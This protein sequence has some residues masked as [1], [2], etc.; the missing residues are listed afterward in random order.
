MSFN[1]IIIMEQQHSSASTSHAYK[2][3][4]LPLSQPQSSTFRYCSLT[5]VTTQFNYLISTPFHR[6][7]N[8]PTVLF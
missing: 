3:H 4:Y 8:S 2:Q 5:L 6:V 1:G 7:T